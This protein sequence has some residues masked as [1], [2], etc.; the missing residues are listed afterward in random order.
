MGDQIIHHSPSRL[1]IQLAAMSSHADEYEEQNVHE[2]YQNIAQHF[3]ATRYKVALCPHHCDFRLINLLD[4]NCLTSHGPLWNN[5]SKI[6]PLA[7]SVLMWDAEMVRTLWST[8]MS[9]LLHQ[10]G[11]FLQKYNGSSQN[12]VG[13]A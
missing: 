9:L 10:I 1:Q 12:I 2:V 4:I 8:E 13:S 11:K 5:T 6:S 3:S 7:L